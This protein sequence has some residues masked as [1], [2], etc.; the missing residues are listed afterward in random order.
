MGFWLTLLSSQVNSDISR[1]L[2]AAYRLEINR[3]NPTVTS[4]RVEDRQLRGRKTE[5]LKWAENR[6]ISDP[7]QP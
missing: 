3:E 2:A 4:F 1:V 5:G 7:P 6:E